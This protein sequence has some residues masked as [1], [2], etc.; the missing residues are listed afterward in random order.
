MRTTKAPPWSSK[1]LLT[2]PAPIL[3]VGMSSVVRLRS[4]CHGVSEADPCFKLSEDLWGHVELS[5]HGDGAADSV[6]GAEAL[7]LPASAPQDS[8]HS[9]VDDTDDPAYA[10]C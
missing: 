8:L 4:G 5:G 6:R 1:G 10:V 9:Q 7:E 3:T 2:S